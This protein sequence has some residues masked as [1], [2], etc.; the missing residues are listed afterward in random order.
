MVTTG[1]ITHRIDRLAERGLVERT[2][3]PDDRRK[4]VVRLTAAGR[5]LVDDVA[6]AHLATEH[7]ILGGLTTRQRRQL[8]DLLRVPL[9]TLGDDAAGS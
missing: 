9:L 7:E 1:A 3:A 5:A 2:A 8:A 6:A 4:V